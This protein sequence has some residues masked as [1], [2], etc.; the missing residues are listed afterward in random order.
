VAPRTPTKRKAPPE[1]QNRRHPPKWRAL[2]YRPT[3]LLC[4][5]V[6]VATGML[7][8]YAI[9]WLPS[10]SDLPEYQVELRATELP[11]GHR[12]VPVDLLDHVIEAE[13]LSS[14]VSV[15]DSSVPRRLTEGLAAHPWVAA[16]HSVRARRGGYLVELE[17]REPAAMIA[18]QSGV[19]AVDV[20]GVVLPPKDFALADVDRFPTVRGVTTRPPDPGERWNDLAVLGAARLATELAPERDMSRNWSR[21]GLAEIAVIPNPGAANRL[22][23]VVYELVTK[24]GSRII[25]GR[26]PGAD[27]LEPSVSQKLGRLDDYLAD[28]ATFDGPDGPQ[29]IDIRHFEVIEVTSLAARSDRRPR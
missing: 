28:F 18:T 26:A 27:D 10:L 24:S 7:H 1:S 6:I 11:A 20:E 22:E 21:Y 3:T 13:G 8:R 29:R 5:A 2:L 25:W 15:L 14:E 9:R 19:H 4:A 17:Y 12:W 16:V 23:E